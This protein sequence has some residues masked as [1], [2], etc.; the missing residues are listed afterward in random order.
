MS[1]WESVEGETPIDPSGL[2]RPGSIKNRRELAAAEAPNI[3]KAIL[4]YLALKPHRRSARFDYPWFLA[5]HK[6]MFGD[7]WVWAGT[8]RTHDVNIGVQHLQIVEQ[9]SA[10]VKDLDSWTGFG[11]SIADQACWL[12]HKAVW[13]HPFQNGNGRWA[14]LLSNIWEKLHDEP[15]VVWPDEVLGESSTVRAEYLA[16]IRRADAGDYSLLSELSGRFRRPR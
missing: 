11:H 8:H 9:L 1:E 13:I 15:I 3:N 5:L 7:V 6:E 12:H 14:R 4:K 16:A 2:K 10:L